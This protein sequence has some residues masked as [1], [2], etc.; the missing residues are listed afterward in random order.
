MLDYFLQVLNNISEMPR[1]LTGIL[2]FIYGSFFGS[3][4]NVVIYRT[5][6]EKP[7]S[8]FKKSFCPHCR[9]PIAF[10]L[11]I[12]ILSW[13]FLRGS[14]TNCSQKISWRYP[15]VEFLMSVLFCTL[16]LAMGWKWFLLESL[17]FGFALLTA[18]IIDID[19]MILPD[20]F[21]LSGVIFGLLGGF[22]NPERSFI[23]SLIGCFAGGGILLFIAFVYYF[24]RRKEGMGGGDIKMMAWIGAVL[25]WESLFFV[26]LV[27]CFLGTFFGLTIILQSN[28]KSF[29]MVFPFGPALALSALIYIFLKELKIMAILDSFSLFPLY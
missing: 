29:Q 19:K 26:L 23:D 16:F 20:F 10:Y 12:P 9:S 14:C 13:F 4:A 24:L 15:L 18:S 8:L 11:N 17:I 21:T 2:F 28:K 6:Q 25:G 3:F 1:W 27:S 22:F 5:Q 7:I